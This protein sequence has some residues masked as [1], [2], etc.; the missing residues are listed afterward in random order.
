MSFS[1]EGC[2]ANECPDSLRDNVGKSKH[3]TSRS[4][5]VLLSR[6]LQWIA[7]LPLINDTVAMR[8]AEF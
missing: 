5:V 4:S 6:P 8:L 2:I 7:M 1:F 3:P